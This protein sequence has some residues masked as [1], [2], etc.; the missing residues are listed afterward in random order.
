MKKLGESL[1]KDLREGD[2]VFLKGPLGSGKT[3]FVK[4][5]ARGLGYPE[6]RVKSPTF[7][8]L[9]IY[10][11]RMKLYHVDLYRSPG[12]LEFLRDVL[13]PEDGILLVEWPEELADL[14]PTVI[15]EIVF[16][17]R[18]RKVSISYG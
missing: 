2:V 12:D 11:G 1:S 9:N 15:V 4:G 3:T 8:F 10:P 18:G 14:K 7:T 6:D 5:I 13:P 16:E 17:G